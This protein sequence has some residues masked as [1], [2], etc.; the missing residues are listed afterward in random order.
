MTTNHKKLGA[1][2]TAIC[3]LELISKFFQLSLAVVVLLKKEDIGLWLEKIG[4]SNIMNAISN[5][6]VMI[7]ICLSILAILGL[8]LILS[9]NRI[10]M[11]LYFPI[12]AINVTMLAIQNSFQIKPLLFALVLPVILFILL[13]NRRNVF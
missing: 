8:I 13:Y 5:Q 11:Y 7:T 2:V 6:Q 9:K 10:G 1:G 4:Q 3:I 12:T